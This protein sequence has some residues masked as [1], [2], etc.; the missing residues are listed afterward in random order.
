MT[1][2]LID[3]MRHT[4]I[5]KIRGNKEKVFYVC[6]YGGCGSKVLC[7]YLGYFG[8][9]KHVHSRQPPINLTHIGLYSQYDEWFSKIPIAKEDLQ[10]YYVIFIY[11]DPIKAIQS[12]FGQKEHLEHIQCNPTITLKQV[13]ETQQDLYG[14][15]NFFDNY[16]NKTTKRNYKIYCV[17]YEDLFNNIEELNRVLNIRCNKDIYPVEKTSN[18]PL[19]REHL[20]L[21]PIYANLIKKMNG[22]KFITNL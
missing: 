13:I 19:S 11:R 10:N 1:N 16:T 18:K 15:E 5:E 6:S 20:A 8:K 7:E 14:I 21:Y 2:R 22:M 12:R 4:T 9:V 3:N 17:K